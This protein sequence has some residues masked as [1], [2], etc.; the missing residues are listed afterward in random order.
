MSEQTFRTSA[1]MNAFA[2][3]LQQ[4]IPAWYADALCP[5]VDIEL[6]FPGKGASNRE[7]KAVCARCPVRQQCLSYALKME[8][9]EHGTTSYGP[10]GVWGGLTAYE[11]RELLRERRATATNESGGAAA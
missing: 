4:V 2:S 7:A 5:Q 10:Y 1:A 3:A 8:A 9:G 11:R 6:F